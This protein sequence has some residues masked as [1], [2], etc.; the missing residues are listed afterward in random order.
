MAVNLESAF[1]RNRTLR[2]RLTGLVADLG[3]TVVADDLKVVRYLDKAAPVHVVITANEVNDLHGTGPL[4]KRICAGWSNV[5]A[6][7]ARNDFQGIQDFGDWQVCMH[8]RSQSRREFFLQTLGFL[9]GLSVETVLCVPYLPDEFLTAIAIQ[10]SFGASLCAYI[11][12]D[13][14]IAQQ[15]IADDLMQ[16]FL[17]C[18]S[19]RLITHPELK[20]AYEDK[21]G[22]PFHLLP[23]IVPDHLVAKQITPVPAQGRRGAMIG[24]FWDQRWFDRLCD[25][26]S[27]CGWEIDWYGNN[28]SPWLRF[29]P[30]RMRRAGI[31]AHG[32]VPENQLA[33]VLKKYPFVIVPSAALDGSDMDEGVA[34]LSLPGRI[35]FASAVSHTPVLVIGHSTTCGARFVKHFGVGESAPYNSGRIL[36][37]MERLSA[38]QEQQRLR[39]RAA[40]VGPMFSDKGVAQWLAASIDLGRPLDGR[41]NDA[42]AGYPDSLRD[43][44]YRSSMRWS[45]SA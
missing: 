14:N 23:A 13:Q 35:L 17:E 42:F 44:P 39:R 21:F 1:P 12:D 15:K 4:V 16:E 33:D 10:K 8:R 30:E 38:A 28:K 5:I 2:D 11:M 31:R 43:A 19:L 25:E 40:E 6:I 32:V 3:N 24:S 34:R 27:P 37:A 7:R 20:R 22:L 36:E 9:R 41:F 29:D 18:C 26:L 45:A